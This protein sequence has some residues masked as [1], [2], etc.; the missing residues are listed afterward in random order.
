MTVYGVLNLFQATLDDSKCMLQNLRVNEPSHERAEPSQSLGP[1]VARFLGWLVDLRA[2][3]T[4][5]SARPARDARRA[6]S[7]L[8]QPWLKIK[9]LFNFNISM[10]YDLL[11]KQIMK[12]ETSYNHLKHLR[13][14][15]WIINQLN[16]SIDQRGL[17]YIILIRILIIFK[18]MKTKKR[19]RF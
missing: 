6:C 15:N 13:N 5:C 10:N 9:I 12:L 4:P 8:C 2:E 17:F 19:K 3:P 16:F 1:L 14:N 7:A 18:N 11:I